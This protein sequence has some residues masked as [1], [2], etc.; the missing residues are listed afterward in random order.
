MLRASLV[1][2]TVPGHAQGVDDSSQHSHSARGLPPLDSLI[3]EITM[4]L[5]SQRLMG[6]MQRLKVVPEDR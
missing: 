3:L 1:A 2:T 5:E 4:D 6:Q